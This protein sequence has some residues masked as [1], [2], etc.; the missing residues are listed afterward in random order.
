MPLGRSICTAAFCT[1]IS[2]FGAISRLQVLI[3][4][5]GDPADDAA[6]VTTSSPFCSASIIVLG[7]FARFI[8]GRIM[9]KYSSTNIRMIGR[10]PI[11]PVSPPMAAWA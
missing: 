1:L 3:A 11:N 9:R 5:L 2:V 6:A 7:S 8:W 4:H 10:K